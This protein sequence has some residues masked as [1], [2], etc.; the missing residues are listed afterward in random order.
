MPKGMPNPGGAFPG[1]DFPASKQTAA[2][3]KAATNTPA[4]ASPATQAKKRGRKSYVKNAMVQKALQKAA[5]NGVH[6]PANGK[7]TKKQAQMRIAAS[8]VGNG[9]VPGGW[10][11]G[12]RTTKIG[13]QTAG[14]MAGFLEAGLI[15]A[16]VADQPSKRGKKHTGLMK[17]SANGGYNTK[18]TEL[19][20]FT[21]KGSEKIVPFLAAMRKTAAEEGITKRIS[22]KTA[23]KLDKAGFGSQLK[24]ETF[25]FKHPKTGNTMTGTRHS[26]APQSNGQYGK[27]RHAAGPAAAT[28]AVKIRAKSQMGKNPVRAHAAKKRNNPT[29]GFGPSGV[30]IS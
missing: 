18:G 25:T 12:E 10:K 11:N 8:K 6:M 3:N 7:M 15:N 30:E 24:T 13:K 26:I 1:M 23:K 14:S 29:G 16:V 19:A 21:T 27:F 2:Q 20:G 22:G 4:A 5:A 17:R 28:R 9:G